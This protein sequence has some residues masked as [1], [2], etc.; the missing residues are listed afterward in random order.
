MRGKAS[1]GLEQSRKASGRRRSGLLSEVPF[2]FGLKRAVSKEAE[3]GE[4]EASEPSF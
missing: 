3:A 1:S 4:L 2:G